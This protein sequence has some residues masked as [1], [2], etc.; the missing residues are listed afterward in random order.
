MKRYSPKVFA[1]ALWARSLHD[2]VGVKGNDSEYH[3]KLEQL[4]DEV[5]IKLQ[6]WSV[7][8]INGKMK[9]G[10]VIAALDKAQIANQ[11]AYADRGLICNLSTGWMQLFNRR[12]TPVELYAECVAIKL[13]L[14]MLDAD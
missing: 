4:N 6:T 14:A 2:Y 13:A 10:E 3:E 11:M 12:P 8:V 1:D 9:K 7:L 5:A